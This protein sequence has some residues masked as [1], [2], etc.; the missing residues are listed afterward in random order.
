M[1]LNNQIIATI[2]TYLDPKKSDAV[3]RIDTIKHPK[4]IEQINA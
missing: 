4:L 1:I 3:T 2:E